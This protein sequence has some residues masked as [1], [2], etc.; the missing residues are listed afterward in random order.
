MN[1]KICKACSLIESSNY[2]LLGTH[3]VAW[4]AA[5]QQVHRAAAQQGVEGDCAGTAPRLLP[6]CFL[7]PSS[8]LPGLLP[9]A[10]AC[11]QAAPVWGKEAGAL[12]PWASGAASGS[13]CPGVGTGRVS[14][15]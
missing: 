1:W 5:G 11:G 4:L 9:S 10:G 15:G 12:S 3:M 6:A 2:S 8:Q 7:V 13:C 14:P